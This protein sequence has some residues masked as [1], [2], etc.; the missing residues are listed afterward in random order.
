MKRRIAVALLAGSLAAAP[1]A[2][3]QDTP[4]P[5]PP[6]VTDDAIVTIPAFAAPFS[7]FASEQARRAYLFEHS[8]AFYTSPVARMQTLAVAEQRR[9]LDEHYLGPLIAKALERFP[10]TIEPRTIGGVYTEV[11]TPAAGVAAEK[12]ERILIN[13]HGGGFTMGARTNGRLESIPVAGRGRYRVVAIDYRQGPEHHFPAASEDVAAVYREL[14][15]SHRP[16]RI[17]LF[18]C[19][20]GGLLAAQ[21][22]AR[23][24]QEGLPGPGAVGI[25]CASAGH[26]GDGDS[27][28]TAPALN[29]RPVPPPGFAGDLRRLAYFAHADPHDP[30]VTPVDHPDVLAKFPPTLLVTATRDM[31]MSSALHTHRELVKA[32]V[33]AELHVW[34]GL[35]HFFFADVDLPESGEAFDVMVD[36]F[37]RQLGRTDAAAERGSMIDDRDAPE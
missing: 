30:L 26:L 32:G 2:S 14:L 37:D 13:L 36:F 17:G 27:G 18:G 12:E 21:A 11:I 16:E 19:S 28:Y 1:A 15:K 4:R 31:A 9:I 20:A 25:F 3:G 5:T 23:F 6:T 7:R 22:L 10:V 29:G 34:D 24:Q 8:P 33:A 35:Q